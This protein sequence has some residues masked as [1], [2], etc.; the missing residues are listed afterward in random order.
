M[1]FNFEKI[2][3][4]FYK[5]FS[6]VFKNFIL[7]CSMEVFPQL[8]NVED[9]LGKIHWKLALSLLLAWIPIFLTLWKGV[10]SSGK[11]AYFTVS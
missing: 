2:D 8:P 6:K 5:L 3:V 1:P 4:L 11:V 7:C 9:G 10:K